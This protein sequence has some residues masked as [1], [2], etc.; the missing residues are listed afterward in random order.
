MNYR[1][2]VV[3]IFEEEMKSSRKPKKT[4]DDIAPA[5]AN[6]EIIT[7]QYGNICLY[8]ADCFDV[9]KRMSSNSVDSAV[10]DPAYGIGFMGH[11][12]DNFNPAVI[13]EKTKNYT[14]NNNTGSTRSASFH[15]G[16]YDTSH[17]GSIRYQKYCKRFGIELWRVMK[18]GAHL[19]SFC[20]PRMVHRLTCGLEDAGFEII[21]MIMW[22]FGTGMPKSHNISKAIDRKLDATREVIGQIDRGNGRQFA[23]GKSGFKKGVVDITNPASQEAKYWDDWGTG[24]KPGYEPIVL[25]RK[26]KAESSITENILL[27]GTG[28]MNIGACRIDHEEVTRGDEGRFPANVIISDE[29]AESLKDRAKFF[30]CPKASGAERNAGCEHFEFPN[31]KNATTSRTYKDRCGVCG[32]RFIGSEDARCQ[33]PNGVK[34]TVKS[35]QKG[36]IHPTVK[37]VRLM[38]YLV[39]LITPMGGT[40]LDIFMGSGG[41]GIAC[42]NLGINFIGIEREA[43]YFKIAEARIEHAYRKLK[44]LKA[45]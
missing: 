10:I 35:E 33:C 4:I 18:P 44:Q 34:K 19:L 27:H 14:G 42:A 3:D 43:D 41:T 32:K 2:D 36:N 5:M 15:A 37:P 20:S 39:K 7:K 6:K 38:E 30:Y 16:Y 23:E 28:G 9:L 11:E 40:C 1:E 13:R 17:S 24:L 45:V 26:P 8:N 12:W 21:D 29:V 25:A 22:L 31:R